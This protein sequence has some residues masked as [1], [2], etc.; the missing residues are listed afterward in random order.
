MT[1]PELPRS[2]SPEATCRTSTYGIQ[3]KDHR[4]PGQCCFRRLFD[5]LSPM[6]QD[7]SR[8]VKVTLTQP[9]AFTSKIVEVKNLS[10]KGDKQGEIHIDAG[11]GVAPYTY[12]WSNGDK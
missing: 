1:I 11:G 10:C 2:P 7:V 5:D 8:T 9:E 3:A 4:R 6:H 12:T